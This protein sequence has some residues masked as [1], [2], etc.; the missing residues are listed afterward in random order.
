MNC[1]W[2]PSGR[3]SLTGLPAGFRHVPALPDARRQ[4]ALALLLPGNCARQNPC[5]KLGLL[6]ATPVWWF[7]AAVLCTWAGVL[8]VHPMRAGLGGRSLVA[9]MCCQNERHPE[10][11]CLGGQSLVALTHGDLV[12]SLA[13][14]K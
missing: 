10:E 2:V 5:A 14:A 12:L 3:T 4:L 11:I 9:L 1:S 7:A 6:T 8:T 13:D